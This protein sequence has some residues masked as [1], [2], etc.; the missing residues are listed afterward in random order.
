M[1]EM[2]KKQR[3]RAKLNKMRRKRINIDINKNGGNESGSKR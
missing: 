1:R 3:D 2:P